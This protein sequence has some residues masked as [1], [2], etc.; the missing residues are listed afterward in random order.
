M[1]T[2][3]EHPAD[4]KANGAPVPR[5]Y[6]ASDLPLPSA[7]RGAIE[8]LAHAFKK[9]GAYDDIRRQVWDKFE[10]SVSDAKQCLACTGSNF[11]FL[12]G[13]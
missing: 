4:A 9:E 12:P 6:K 3:K 8:S 2:M 11:F 13:L 5:K 7:T 1:A 10:A